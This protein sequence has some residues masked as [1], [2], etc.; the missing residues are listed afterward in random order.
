[1]SKVENRLTNIK[2]IKLDR[3]LQITRFRGKVA[4]RIVIDSRYFDA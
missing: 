3:Y 1:M 2:S 4:F